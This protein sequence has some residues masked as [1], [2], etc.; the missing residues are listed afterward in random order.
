M[1]NR[2]KYFINMCAHDLLMRLN[3]NLKDDCIL[4][5]ILEDEYNKTI[6]QKCLDAHARG[7]VMSCA[8]CIN[9]WLNEE[10]KNS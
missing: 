4:G 7:C 8:Q 6:Y 1:T 9:S 10:A 2:K 3:S 5:L